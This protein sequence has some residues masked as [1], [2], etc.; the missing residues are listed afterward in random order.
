MFDEKGEH[1][2]KLHENRKSGNCSLCIIGKI[3]KEV[4]RLEKFRDFP[5]N[6]FFDYLREEYPEEFEQYVNDNID[7]F[8]IN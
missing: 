8:E 4:K 5:I 7:E 6:L 1:E 3:M 2:Y